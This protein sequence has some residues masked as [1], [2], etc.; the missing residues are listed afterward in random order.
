MDRQAGAVCYRFVCDRYPACRRARGG[1]CGV[2]WD[3]P[4]EVRVPR[5][6]CNEG[7]GWAWYL[8]RT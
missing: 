5:E 8:P 3:D 2:D 7:D 1:G 6:Q 4:D